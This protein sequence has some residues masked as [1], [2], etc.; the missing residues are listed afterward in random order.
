MNYHVMTLFPQLIEQ[1]TDFSIIKR[2]KEEGRI[3]VSAHDIRD[4]SDNKHKKVDDYPFGGGAGMVMS[5]QPIVDCHRAICSTLSGSI[6]TVYLSPK[7]KLFHQREAKRLLMYDH[8][9]LLCGHYEGVDQ[10]AIDS[11][12]D[13]EISIGD[14]VLTGGEIPAIVLIEATARL[15][16]EVLSCSASHEEESF[17]IPLLEYP[18]YTRPR[19]YEGASVPDVLLSGNHQ[20]IEDWRFEQSLRLTL[21]RRAELLDELEFDKRRMKIYKKV[22]Q[23]QE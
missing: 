23:E 22:L 6:R 17:S 2:A 14:Y 19:E 20:A 16:D 11:I 3:S 4:Y 8:L 5:P 10:R 13:E 18:Q 9:I 15:V 21:E 7:G 12:V 1:A